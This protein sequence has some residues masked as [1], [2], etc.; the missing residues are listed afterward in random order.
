MLDRKETLCIFLA[1]VLLFSS[2][3]SSFSSFL[4][5]GHLNNNSPKAYAQTA[6]L[7]LIHQMKQQLQQQPLSSLRGSVISTAV[8]Q[9]GIVNIPSQPQQV[10]QQQPSSSLSPFNSLSQQQRLASSSGVSRYYQN[11]LPEN[12]RQLQNVPNSPF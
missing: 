8:P 4:V 10:Q 1:S 7:G 12:S 11:Q 6:A 5:M 2:L 3:Y 9:S